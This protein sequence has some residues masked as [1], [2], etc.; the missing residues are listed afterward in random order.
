MKTLL[1]AATLVFAQAPA[2]TPAKTLVIRSLRYQGFKGIAP[3][4]VAS[5]FKD[6]GVRVAVEQ[7]YDPAQVD[8]ARTVLQEL[9]TE[10]GSMAVEVTSAVRQV[11]PRS[12]EVT[13]QAVTK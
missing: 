5:R 1:L 9:L 10:K 13:F 7:A 6:R 12:V 3:D 11:P 4:E 2:Q 8:S